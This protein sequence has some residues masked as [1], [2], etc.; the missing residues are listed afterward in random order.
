MAAILGREP[1]DEGGLPERPEAVAVADR[2]DAGKEGVDEDRP[3]VLA[4]ANVVNVEVAR[5]PGRMRRVERVDRPSAV[6]PGA[7]TLS[8][9][10]I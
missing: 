3:P 7:R 5:H 6:W 2:G 9:R 4:E 1:R 10:W 8:K